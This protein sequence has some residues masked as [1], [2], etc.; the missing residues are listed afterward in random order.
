[1]PSQKKELSKNRIKLSITVP[2]QVMSDFFEKEYGRLAPTVSLSG[3]RPGKAPRVMTIEA[4]GH[5]RL[6]QGAVT[7]AIDRSYREALLE[8]KTY[9]VTQPSISI[10]KHPSFDLKSGDNELAYEVEFD[11]LPEAKIGNYKKIKVP[12]IDAEKLKVTQDEVEQVVKY[13]LRQQAKLTDLDR[14]A[15]KGDWAQVNFKGYLKGVYK[16]KLSSPSLPLVLGETKVI[17]GFEDQIVGMKKDENKKFTLAFP[18]DFQD[19]E[20]ASKSVD[21]ELHLEQLKEIGLPE[22]DKEFAKKFGHD[23]LEKMKRAIREGLEKEKLDREKQTQRAA[24]SGQIIKMTNVSIPK[25]LIDNEAA[26]LKSLLEQDLTKQGLSVEKYLER[27]KMD[28]KRFDRDLEEQAKRNITLGVGLGEVGKKEGM[29]LAHD[30]AEKV[31]E[32]IIELCTR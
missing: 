15:K 25:S 1:M 17:P 24:I 13:L 10:S 4:I 27:T 22:A 2:P 28:Q 20:F 29:N 7:A 14:P 16:E 23:N 30:S 18:K 19:K 8:H 11:I 3:F 9:P 21:F 26:R 31:Y 5:N 12:K 6:S 32:R